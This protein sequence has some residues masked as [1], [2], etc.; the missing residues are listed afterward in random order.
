[1]CT[2]TLPLCLR[3]SPFHIKTWF[4]FKIF[5]E[6]TIDSS[7]HRIF[8]HIYGALNIDKKIK[9]ITQFRRN[10]RDESFKSN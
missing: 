1:V 9:L 6:K 3:P 5:R 7:L 4:S 10:E 2:G 8:G